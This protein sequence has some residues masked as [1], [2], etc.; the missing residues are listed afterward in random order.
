MLFYLF[1]WN[2][3]ICFFSFYIKENVHAQKFGRF[4]GLQ[5]QAAIYPA[6]YYGKFRMID[7]NGFLSN[8]IVGFVDHQYL[9]KETIGVFDI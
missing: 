5:V 9:S 7:S 2:L 1:G 8:Q 6:W 4:R 3:Q